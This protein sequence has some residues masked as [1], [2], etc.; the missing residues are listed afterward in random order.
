MRDLTSIREQYQRDGLD[1]ADLA[2]D[3]I[4]QFERWYDQWAAT[5]P[6]DAAAMV[7]ATV[8]P[9]GHPAARYVL[10]RTVDRHGFVFFTNYESAK[11]RDL[12]A[13]P[14]AA[15]CFG[16]LD[17]QRQVRVE[18]RVEKI[19]DEESDR[20][21]AGRP[22]RSQLAA[23]T[24]PQSDVIVDRKVLERRFG[25]LELSHQGADVPRPAN[26]GGFRVVPQFVE[27][28]QG[29][30]DRLHDRFRYRRLAGGGWRIE[31]LAP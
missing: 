13:N 23:W 15:L 27:F 16:W 11:G 14:R 4:E 2:V 28:W 29:Q 12:D 9:S 3:P 5:E 7:L 31:R 6:Y 20:Y 18:G 25:D 21:F 24:S 17:L 26:W 19:S 8:D 10:L 1:R 30:P 22:R